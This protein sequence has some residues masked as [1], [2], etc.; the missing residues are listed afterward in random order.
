MY[1]R[2]WWKEARLFW[3]IWA[4]L[5]L[6][7]GVAQLLMHQYASPEFR[8]TMLGPL[9]I[10][11]ASLNAFAV[12][13]AAF[14]GERET[15]TLRL[16]DLLPAP[17][18]VVWAGKASFAIVT[19][20][21]LAAVLLGLAALD[22]PGTLERWRVRDGLDPVSLGA[23]MFQ[24]LAWGLLCSAMLGSALL[25][26]VSALGITAIVHLVTTAVASE[27]SISPASQ[28][29]ATPAILAA[30]L[31]AFAWDWRTR[32]AMLGTLAFAGKAALGLT[33]IGLALAAPFTGVVP[34]LPELALDVAPAVLIALV[35]V[36]AWGRLNRLGRLGLRLR[37]PIEVT[38]DARP[39]EDTERLR[40]SIKPAAL[41]ELCEM[42]SIAAPV[43]EAGRFLGSAIL[44]ADRPR[45]RSRM[46]E[47]RSLIWE[48][49][50]EGRRTWL[51][52]LAI[53]LV[54]PAILL[55]SSGRFH[56]EEP[57]LP[58]ASNGL[59]AVVAGVSVFGL[60]NRRRSFRFLVHHGARPGL[61]WLAK[62][63][64]WSF[65][66]AVIW[67]P[68]AYLV[69]HDPGPPSAVEH[70]TLLALLLPLGFSVGALCGMAIPRGITALVVAMVLALAGGGGE[71]GL[72]RVGMLPAWG[73]LV[74]PAALLAG[75]WAWSGDWL[76]DRPAPG[77]WVRLGLTV[78]LTLAMVF[79]GYTGWRAWSI[80]DIGPI[81]PPTAW[82]VASV[83]LPTD[84][85]AADLYREAGRLLQGMT[86][87]VVRVER[88]AQGVTR[89]P[90]D[91]DAHPE[92]F[93]PIRLATARP[94]CRFFEPDRLDLRRR[95][96]LPPMRELADAVA[97]HARG[98]SRRGDLGAAWDDIVLLLRMA[99]HLDQ[100]AV[101]DLTREAL[102]IEWQA[103]EIAREWAG[104]PGQT[105]DRL[106]AAI[107]SYLALPPMTPA[108]ESVRGEGLLV[109]RT[110]QLPADDLKSWLLDT[111]VRTA[112]GGKVSP[113]DILRIDLIASPWERARAV[114]LVR[115]AVAE[116]ARYVSLEPWKRPIGP[117]SV[118]EQGSSPEKEG[119][120]L[121][122]LLVPR[123]EGSR[124]TNDRNEVA[125]RALILV[126]AV[127]EWQLRHDGRFPDRLDDVV[128]DPLPSLPRDPYTG[129]P[130]GYTTFG[131]IVG[132]R[133][134]RW[135]RLD[136][137][138]E[139]R[140][141]YS[142]G[143]D[144]RDDLGLFYAAGADISGDVAFPVFPVPAL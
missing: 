28:L 125:R 95:G 46:A 42:T 98:R 59:I 97:A 12:G 4:F 3:P 81:P 27:P 144:G 61:V 21:A 65:G 10:L 108:E 85:N 141:I 136:W 25:S 106:R 124:T 126:L 11:W 20:T 82:A 142:A 78:A 118:I 45:P 103:L 92:I 89:E 116:E 13:A 109:E 140:L 5:I 31:V 132:H 32:R 60:E 96:F 110:L 63:M 76:L 86:F 138:P 48:T 8:G 30:S 44:S 40:P 51:T 120:S 1:M 79:T 111:R 62:L 56:F 134:P 77:R 94:D 130:F 37:L 16:L 127:R 52:L 7:A 100:G 104:N 19:T 139:T 39:R 49:M 50:R 41:P 2:L 23:L 129:R 123:I 54:C 93:D 55:G 115:E 34:S 71:V 26:A 113:Q 133:P 73:M 119:F 70:W 69:V 47:L 105:P 38:W 72:V 80:P 6:A 68:L 135:P 90:F 102:E 114:R 84:L 24:G 112:S 29:A 88:T 122:A 36:L 143:S 33:A 53:G 66:L 128:P 18:P 67:S 101:M 131:R 107:L 121:A 74:L 87:R 91:L 43:P 58:L 17:R 35:A 57:F 9:A 14:A 22:A 75:T 117:P 99:R 15:G 83:P 137:S 64:A